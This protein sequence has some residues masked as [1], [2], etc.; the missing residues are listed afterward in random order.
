MNRRPTRLP[1]VHRRLVVPLLAGVLVTIGT[2]AIVS[3]GSDTADADPTAD[4]V[5]TIVA[6]R[7]IAAGTPINE[8]VDSVEVRM[9]PGD[10][11][12]DGVI[13]TIGGRPDG[14]P[15]LAAH[16][17]AIVTTDLVV[18][19][20]LLIGDIAADPVTA[21]A[22]DYVAVS[23][24]LDPQRWTGPYATTGAEVDVY[25]TGD[26]TTASRIVDD[27]RIIAAPDITDLDPRSEAIITLAV[28]AADVTAVI[29]A[30]SSSTIWLVGS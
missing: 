24:R 19:E 25:A 21:I 20:Q 16:A 14:I 4:L 29:D 13:G 23:V 17:D 5:A 3:P 2:L 27:A 22:P 15:D 8:I 11:R 28:P 1:G 30:A 9:L 12:A 26:D 18:G 6:S 7:P 10:A